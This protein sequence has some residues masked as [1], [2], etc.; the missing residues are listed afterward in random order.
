VIVQEAPV[1]A[2]A[3]RSESPVRVLTLSARDP[4]A[5]VEL[6]NRFADHLKSNDDDLDD[7][8][9]TSN[10]GRTHFAYRWACVINSR[11][12]CI[13]SLEQFVEQG[14]SGLLPIPSGPAP[15]F[16]FCFPEQF[17]LRGTEF[18]CK[19]DSY[20]RDIAQEAAGAVERALGRSL[21]ELL[22]DE[23]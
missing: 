9:Y 10:V 23:E 13:R 3:L 18:L 20:C 15:K 8:C 12:E 7:V 1:P 22:A 6:A 21:A 16:A 19:P 4:V 14:P 2:L 17:D 5:L 11:E